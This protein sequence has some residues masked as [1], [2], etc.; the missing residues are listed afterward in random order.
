M[1]W[2]MGLVNVRVLKSVCI[3]GFVY[4]CVCVFFVKMRYLIWFVVF[5]GRMKDMWIRVVVVMVF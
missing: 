5:E 4:F 2:L 3:I 1:F